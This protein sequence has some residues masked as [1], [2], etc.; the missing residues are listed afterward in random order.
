M[1]RLWTSALLVGAQSLVW[2]AAGD[3]GVPSYTG[4]ALTTALFTDPNCT[5]SPRWSAWLEQMQREPARAW[6]VGQQAAEELR[7]EG[8]MLAG[9][10]RPEDPCILGAAT[11]VFM[12]AL[13][14]WASGQFMSTLSTFATLHDQFLTVMHPSFYEMNAWPL[15]DAEIRGMKDQLLFNV[16]KFRGLAI[17]RSIEAASQEEGGAPPLSEDPGELENL[18]GFAEHWKAQQRQRELRLGPDGSGGSAGL[19]T[20]VP[21]WEV[22]PEHA[23][24]SAPSVPGPSSLGGLS[25]ARPEGSPPKIFVYD[26]TLPSISTL[27]QGPGFC[28]NRQWGMDVGFH[29]FFRVSPLRTSD[30]DEADFFFVPAYAMC[31]QVA[32]ILELDDAGAAFKEVVR[33]LPYFE[34]TRGRDHIFSLHYVDLFSDWRELAPLSIF[35]TPETEVGWEASRQEFALDPALHPPFDPYKD[36]SVPCFVS[37]GHALHLH[38][39][40]K[41]LAERS[42]I[43]AFAGKLWADVHEAY[44]VRS[45]IKQHLGSK[46]RVAIVVGD[47]MNELL[48]PAAMAEMMGNA[49]FC[50]VPRGRAA[51]S[52]RFFETLWAGCVPV[53][54]SDHYEVPFDALFDVSEFV[55]KWPVEQI[56]D[57]LY[58]YL[59]SLPDDVVETYRRAAARVRC[60]YLFPPPEVSWLGNQNAAREVADVEAELCPNLSSSRNAFQAVVEL[61][62][63]R[64]RTSK[65]AMGSTFYWPEVST[66]PGMAAKVLVT[67]ADLQPLVPT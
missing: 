61:L 47:S 5:Q 35:L 51:W 67:N 32:G 62:S 26:E 30:P 11:L 49:R 42:L 39:A 22:L 15:R 31:L 44:V 7:Q 17:A 14:A 13:T 24:G 4:D 27:T 50:L 10:M 29:D 52:V 46:P 16:R 9:M 54:L 8:D 25:T 23:L 43:A 21:E 41:P 53:L 65:S 56:D 6:L 28:H 63:R 66:E 1:S 60:W 55:V 18:Q 45:R 19:E 40:A 20:L 57:S 58:E 59:A 37:L 3:L 48:S 33:H 36:I 34:R 12:L 2:L 38:R 64:V